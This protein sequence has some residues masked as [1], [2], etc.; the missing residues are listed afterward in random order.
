MK[1]NRQFNFLDIFKVLVI[2]VLLLIQ[3]LVF[4]LFIYILND[5]ANYYYALFE[6]VAIIISL[7]ILGS[8]KKYIYKL[9]WSVFLIGVPITA[10]AFYLLFGDQRFIRKV[11]KRE[12]Q[13]EKNMDVCKTQNYELVE[14]LEEG[15]VKRDISSLF[16]LASYP[17]YYSQNSKYF[18]S[19]ESYFA[20]MLDNLRL[21]EK[22][23][24]I[25]FYIF[26]R[27]QL[28]DRLKEVLI[29]RA[30]NGVDVYIIYDRL[31][32]V[33]RFG[34]EEVE[35]LKNA[36]IRIIGFNK[37]IIHFY[38]FISY[39]T[40][41]KI[42]VI[43]GQVAY[44]GGLNL[45]DEYINIGS[46]YG[47]WKDMG[48]KIQGESTNSFIYA[49]FKVWMLLT[50]ENINILEYFNK[51]HISGYK[52]DY[53]IV[54]PFTDEP[55]NDLEIASHNYM[56]IISGS[57]EYCY[58]TTPYLIIDEEMISALKLSAK[59][60]V[61]VRI[62]IPG[63][64]D[65]KFVYDVTLAHTQE[66]IASGVKIYAYEPGFIHGKTI[67]SD[68]LF[69]TVGSVNF[70]FRSLM[71]NYECAV[72]AADKQLAKDIK[73]DFLDTLSKS[74]LLNDELHN[75]NNLLSRMYRGLLRLIGPLF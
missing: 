40:H 15:R 36:G 13:I 9:S 34:D 62:I 67:V 64:A 38:R 14:Q 75:K 6:V 41:R 1:I 61:D 50:S 23:I 49:F 37:S 72:Y 25:E 16:R 28:Y 71:W 65:K 4:Y 55:T 24:L 53:G 59:S 45:A 8:N 60:G 43:D 54:V 21:A 27:G 58:I 17:A 39:R 10:I 48:I 32:S 31:G 26:A 66:L 30:S 22:Y 68:D 3:F 46:K 56:R 11:Q 12:Q 63:I 74:R 33:G 5:V 44:T 35:E 19:G 7:S 57:C 47:H 29:E 52:P 69:A 70:D 51:Q 42:V 18:S 73:S 20:D 2:I